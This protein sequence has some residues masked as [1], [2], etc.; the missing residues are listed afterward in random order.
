MKLRY[1]HPDNLHGDWD[2]L[3]ACIEKVVAKT[4]ER[5]MKVED[6]YWQIKTNNCGAYVVGDHEGMVILQPCP[7]WDGKELYI[8]MAYNDG[9]HDVVEMCLPEITEVAKT[10][11]AKRLKF[12]SVRKG[13]GRYAEGIGF[14]QDHVLYSKELS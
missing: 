9:T 12:Q 5:L 14:K 6:V 7:G 10:I 2:Y 1:V 8:F 4:D 3:K 13:F 11:G